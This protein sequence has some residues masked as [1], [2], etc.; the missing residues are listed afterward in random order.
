MPEATLATGRVS[1]T[2]CSSSNKNFQTVV[3]LKACCCCSFSDSEDLL[4]WLFSNL[5]ATLQLIP[6]RHWS[7]WSAWQMAAAMAKE[8]NQAVWHFFL[9]TCGQFALTM[10]ADSNLL[11]CR[12]KWSM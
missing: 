11:P 9:F 10:V 7:S 6:R 4:L 12:W 2:H 1:T 3:S 5:P 8:G